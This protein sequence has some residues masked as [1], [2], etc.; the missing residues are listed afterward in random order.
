MK[1]LDERTKKIYWLA[2]R[3]IDLQKDLTKLSEYEKELYVKRIE[4]LKVLKKEC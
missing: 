1:V 4:E 3:Y 2:K